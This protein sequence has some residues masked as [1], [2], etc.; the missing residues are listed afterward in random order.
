MSVESVSQ[1]YQTIVQDPA[2]KQQF[3][4]AAKSAS[5]QEFLQMAVEQGQKYGYTFTTE[6]VAQAIAAAQIPS[7]TDGNVELS[8]Y[9][10]EAVAGGGPKTEAAGREGASAGRAVN[11]T[12]N[13]GLLLAG[14]FA[15]S[16]FAGAIE[17]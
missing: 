12:L 17:D 9:Q 4:I 5:D 6:E 16:M 7:E 1:F 10:L 11:D 2:L 15:G 3:G 14:A 8:D 13:A